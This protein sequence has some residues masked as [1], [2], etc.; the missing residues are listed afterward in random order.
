MTAIDTRSPGY[1]RRTVL[2]RLGAIGVGFATGGLLAA[3]GSAV[4]TS[5]SAAVAS[6]TAAAPVATS[7]TA[8]LQT[9]TSLAGSTSSTPAVSNPA[10]TV[11][12][13]AATSQ[14][15]AAPGKAQIELFYQNWDDLTQYKDSY[16]AWYN[17]AF[18]AF[19]QQHP[20]AKV[21][22]VLTPFGSI[23]EKIIAGVAGGT[24]VD[25][26]TMSIL[27]GRDLYDKQALNA[28]DS[29]IAKVKELSPSEFFDVANMYRSSQGK[30][31]AL[32]VYAD[33]SMIG[34]NSRML[35]DVGLDPKA[36]DVKTWDDLLRYS[37]R[38]TKEDGGKI[39]QLGFPYNLPGLEE[40]ATWAY[41]NGGEVQDA[42][43]TKALFNSPQVADMLHYRATQ[44]Q[45]FGVNRSTD[46][47]G[48]LFKIQKQAMEHTST[49]LQVAVNGGTY[50]PKGFEYWF[51]P[52][53]KGPSGSGPGMAAW[54]NMVGAPTGVKHL[55]LSFD[56]LQ[57]IAGPAGLSK[58][59]QYAK[60]YP[61]LK[62]FYQTDVFAQAVKQDPVL[63]IP[64]TLFA[65]GKTYPF[66]RRYNDVNKVLG[67]LISDAVA[68]KRDVQQSLADGAQQVNA[69]LQK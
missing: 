24:P 12:S 31:Y 9:S 49:A 17:W 33:V 1:S 18:D 8:Q 15:A 41:A 26:S 23:V 67:P 14:A 4:S 47:K 52:T 5:T 46:L 44:Y 48:D 60:I 45:R 25:G 51:I 56:L 64:P 34:M 36:Q 57:S 16:G 50:V 6:S 3:C 35:S 10:T 27:H 63:G 7:A 40:F 19:Q 28:L 53:P 11:A 2:H 66:F 61:A 22:Y 65:Q 58:M 68:G 37:D 29:Y 39:T 55:D 59:F 21:Q 20:E 13:A 62:S 38:L 69:I 32:S 43:V 54:V 30:Y 42:D